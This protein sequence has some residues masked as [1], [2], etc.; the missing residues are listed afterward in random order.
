VNGK[1]HAIIEPVLFIVRKNMLQKLNFNFAQN[2]L[3]Q[4]GALTITQ[5]DGFTLMMTVPEHEFWKGINIEDKEPSCCFYM[6]EIEPGIYE[7][8]L[9]F[10]H[11]INDLTQFKVIGSYDRLGKDGLSKR[12][13]R[14]SPMVDYFDN[15]VECY[16]VADN[17]EQIKE[18]YKDQIASNNPIV[19][20]VTEINKNTQPEDGGWRW[21][22]WGQYIGT[23]EP[24]CE[25]IYDEP[26]I[27]SVFVFHAYSVKLKEVLE[28][29]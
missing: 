24:Q 15:T 8:G 28:S 19:I 7:A 20:S 2:K 10:E 14:N 5:E 6:K 4:D 29:V 9:N 11:D 16:G 12:Y 25:Y 3:V 22:K 1:F 21:H 23:M 17:I 18:F 26:E 13:E 27:D